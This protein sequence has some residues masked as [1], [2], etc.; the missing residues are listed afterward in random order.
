[1]LI[2][3][4][5]LAGICASVLFTGGM[6]LVE[7]AVPL[8]KRPVYIA[9]IG[10]MFGLSAILG[11]ILGG[12]IT[13]H[14][15]WRWCF[16]IN[17]PLGLVAGLGIL[18]VRCRSSSARDQSLLRKIVNIRLGDITI[19]GG[20][21]LCLLVGL[22]LASTSTERTDSR[23][24]VLLVAFLLLLSTFI[25]IQIYLGEK[26]IVPPRLIRQRSVAASCWFTCFLSMGT[27]T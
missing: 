5:A 27:F 4:R 1:M 16:W 8:A 24:I 26:G 11:P 19:L 25:G 17:L 10:S 20:A 3:A 13:A 14:L 2:S 6:L 18:P 7:D 21:L 22:Q 23:V 9:C 12:V 15:S